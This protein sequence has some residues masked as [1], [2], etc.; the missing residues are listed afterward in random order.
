MKLTVTTDKTARSAGVH[1]AGDL[2]FLSTGEF[3]DAV[4]TLVSDQPGLCHLRLDFAALTFCDSAGLSG[5]IDIH[6][7]AAAAGVQLH[8]DRRPAHLDRVLDITGILD[9]L[10]TPPAVD[11]ATTGARTGPA[12]GESGLG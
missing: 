7:H 10:T 6:R 1:I 4:C 12:A 3:V 2:D 5:L 9:H 11:G 8:L